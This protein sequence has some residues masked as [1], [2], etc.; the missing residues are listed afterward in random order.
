MKKL[1]EQSYSELM[2]TIQ[3]EVEKIESVSIDLLSFDV[4]NP[5]DIIDYFQRNINKSYLRC[6]EVHNCGT[7][8]TILLYYVDS[9]QDKVYLDYISELDGVWKDSTKVEPIEV[10]LDLVGKC[11]VVIINSIT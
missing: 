11:F 4:H 10:K 2:L 9:P 6:K 5:A 8:A 3:Q 7:T 1:S